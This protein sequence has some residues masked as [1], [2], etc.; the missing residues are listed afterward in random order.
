MATIPQVARAMREILTTTAD[1]AARTT[2]FVQRQ[3]RLGGATF[4][5][6]LVFGF[7]S[8]P[9]A[10]LEELAQTAATLGVRITP[11]ALDQRFTAA[12]A[13]CLAQVLQGAIRRVI[14]ADPVAIPFLERFTAVYLQDSSTIV[15]PDILAT[16]WRGGGGSTTARTSAALKLQV[17]VEFRTGC[18][19]NCQLQDGRTPDQRAAF[20]AGL[21]AG[22]LRLADLGYWSLEALQSMAQ[23]GTFWLSRLQ[24]QTAVYDATGQRQDLLALL[25]A[26]PTATM[27]HEIALGAEQRVPAR[28][29]AVRVPQEVA[30]AR[31]RR[32]RAGAQTASPPPGSAWPP[33]P[34]SPPLACPGTTGKGTGEEGQR[35]ADWS[36][37]GP[38]TILCTPP[39]GSHPLLGFVAHSRSSPGGS[40]WSRRTECPSPASGSG[41][42]GP[43]RRRRSHPR[44]APFRAL[45]SPGLAQT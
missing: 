39:S 38:C 23:Q 6:T 18:L 14:A 25:E 12:A 42:P 32:M 11:Q 28:L 3:S 13:T 35:H 21:L 37:N 4:S 26:Q 15:L 16:V 30:D 27:E 44:C 8:N 45:P 10:T 43:R 19:E 33:P 5:Q 22:A 9:Q 17:R 36:G 29:L 24:T 40:P 41:A 20:P 31:R 34:G 2:H 1:D 7:L